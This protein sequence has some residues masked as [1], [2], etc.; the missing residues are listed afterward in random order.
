LSCLRV[1]AVAVDGAIPVTVIVALP[2]SLGLSVETMNLIVVELD[3]VVAP[4]TT[5]NAGRMA[6]VTQDTR[7]SATRTLPRPASPAGGALQV[8]VS[9]IS[10]RSLE[11]FSFQPA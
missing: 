7:T 9:F 4:S 11:R 1:S 2:V 10:F 3:E 6:A 8:V 5:A